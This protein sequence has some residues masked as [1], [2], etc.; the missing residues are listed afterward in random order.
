MKES[1]PQNWNYSKP[2][3]LDDEMR[4]FQP[5]GQFLVQPCNPITENEEGNRK[6]EKGGGTKEIS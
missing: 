1:P 6:E 5:L 2:F 4:Q 3:F